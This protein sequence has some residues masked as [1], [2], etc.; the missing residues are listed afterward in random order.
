M[1]IHHTCL[2]YAADVLPKTYWRF[3]FFLTGI[4]Y[5]Q[6]FQF[7][8]K[9]IIKVQK[10]TSYSTIDDNI[11]YM[12]TCSHYN[13]NNHFNTVLLHKIDSSVLIMSLQCKYFTSKLLRKPMSTNTWLAFQTKVSCKDLKARALNEEYE[14]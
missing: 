1:Y 12:Y 3:F 4:L 6:L 8:S 5:T 7:T 14:A 13:N 9:T 2:E 11:E 10:D